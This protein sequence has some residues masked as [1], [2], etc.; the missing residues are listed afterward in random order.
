MEKNVGKVDSIIR[1]ILGIILVIAGLAYLNG[2]AEVV[3]IIIGIVLIF[4]SLTK[5]CALYKLFGINT[6]KK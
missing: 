4:T 6:L 5:F 3:V 2:V 1:L